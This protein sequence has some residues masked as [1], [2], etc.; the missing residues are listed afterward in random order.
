[1]VPKEAAK[2]NPWSWRGRFLDHESQT[3]I[4]LLKRGYHIGF[5]QSD[6]MKYWQA[7]FEFVTKKHGLS[8][9]PALV[10]MSGG[11]RNAF[12]WATMNPDHVSC[13]YA[14][15]PL[16]TRESLMKLDRLIERD[17]PLLHVCGSLDPLSVNH[18]YPIESIYHQLGGRISVMIKDSV[19]HVRVAS[20]RSSRQ[21][22]SPA[23]SAIQA[24]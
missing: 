5:I 4:A 20:R 1:M 13:I 15:N 17:V 21:T 16:I 10:G 7:W 14:D 18:T 6:D 8:H 3:E 19:G 11:G 23:T 24:G 9:K 22:N 12:N 2:A